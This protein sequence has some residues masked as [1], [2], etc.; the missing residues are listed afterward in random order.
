MATQIYKVRDPSG[1]IREIEGPEGATDEQVIAKAKELFA[2][3]AP[4]P[5]AESMP[6]DRTSSR[7]EGTMDA[8]APRRTPLKFTGVNAVMQSIG[9]P[10]Q[11]VSE[12]AIKGGSNIL[13]GAEQLYGKGFKAF[14]GLF[15]QNQNLSGLITGDQPLNIGQQVGNM[16]IRDALQ[17]QAEAQSRVAPF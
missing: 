5:V 7:T 13:F 2:A 16:I 9:A 10:I 4:A 12:G 15:P 6:S 8:Y 11:A 3:P 14:S 1:A 17:R